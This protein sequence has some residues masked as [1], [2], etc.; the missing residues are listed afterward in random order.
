[1]SR[2]VS[3]MFEALQ[4][5]AAGPLMR[6]PIDGAAPSRPDQGPVWLKAT[7]HFA[8]DEAAAIRAALRVRRAWPQ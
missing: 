8:A 3:A 5:P 2:T 6:H 4:R 7:P 1:M